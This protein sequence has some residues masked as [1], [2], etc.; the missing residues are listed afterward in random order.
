M[1]K[2]LLVVNQMSEYDDLVLKFAGSLKA[3]GAKELTVAKTITIYTGKK[4]VDYEG[5]DIA[6]I[7][8]DLKAQGFQ[9]DVKEAD[10]VPLEEINHL[11]EKEE[12]YESLIVVGARMS[13]LGKRLFDAEFGYELIQNPSRPILLVRVDEGEEKGLTTIPKDGFRLD[14]HV[15][16]PTD[17]SENAYYAFTFLEKMVELGLKKVTIMHI[18]DIAT[19]SP[20]LEYRLSE[21]NSIDRERL[22]G[23][24]ERL[25]AKGDVEVDIILDIGRPFRE[26]K[27]FV[28]ENPVDLLL[29]GRQGKG[30]LKDIFIGSNSN[31]VARRVNTSIL[32]IPRRDTK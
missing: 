18:Q 23:L 1:F 19:I 30:L 22:H 12:D 20:Y 17:F 9:V 8:D 10:R 2:K 31:N 27:N 29:M 24:K 32:L 3:L 15:L 14:G 11:L 7:V 5:P 21:F 16:F 25:E 4:I 6:S 28:E 26:I 13:S